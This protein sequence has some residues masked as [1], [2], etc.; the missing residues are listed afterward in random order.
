MGIHDVLPLDRKDEDDPIFLKKILK[1]EGAWAV[2]K[3]VLG[4]NFDGNPG[5]HTIWPTKQRWDDILAV[6]KKWI[7]EGED[8]TKDILFEEFR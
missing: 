6:I 2:V 4:F 5:E 8:I 3:Y 7:R 1:K